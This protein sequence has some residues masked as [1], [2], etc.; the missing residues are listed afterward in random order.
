MTHDHICPDCGSGMV[1][2][3]NHQTKEPFWGCTQYPSC[4]ST[5]AFEGDGKDDAVPREDI[6]PSERYRNTDR[7][8]WRNE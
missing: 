2:R 6:L 1:L 8:R 5:R 4:T 7:R 3:R